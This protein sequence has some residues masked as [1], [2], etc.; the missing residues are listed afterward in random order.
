MSKQRPW[1]QTWIGGVRSA[2]VDLGYPGQ[3]LGLPEEG[4][5]SVAGF[6]RRLAALMIDWLICT[7]A[8]AQGLLGM[9]SVDA[10]WV[11]L[12]VFAVENVLL[13]GTIGMTF[14]MRLMNIRVATL[15]RGRP[16]WVP[17][18]ARTVLLCLAV[19]AVMLDRDRRGIHDRVSATVV[20]R[21]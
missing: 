13:V 2:G 10:A 7:W 5:D 17:T 16:R 20:V 4:P 3:R 18:I 9:S 11:G 14:G 6:G 19:P 15:D 12:L 8:I 21:T 1:T